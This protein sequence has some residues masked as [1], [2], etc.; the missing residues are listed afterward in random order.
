MYNSGNVLII[1]NGDSLLSSNFPCTSCFV[2]VYIHIEF[3]Y[4]LVAN[5]VEHPFYVIGQNIKLSLADK[6][7]FVSEIVSICNAEM[8]GLLHVYIYK[9]HVPSVHSKVVNFL[10]IFL[11]ILSLTLYFMN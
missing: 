10:K 6:K 1:S 5:L 9:I 4:S 3:L 2:S 7:D 8:L 11:C